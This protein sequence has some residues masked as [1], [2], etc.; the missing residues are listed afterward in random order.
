MINHLIDRYY[1]F[2][3]IYIYIIYNSIKQSIA[4]GIVRK[5]S[6]SIDMTNDNINL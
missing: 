2:L 1:H 3:Y 6:Q 4:H 5:N